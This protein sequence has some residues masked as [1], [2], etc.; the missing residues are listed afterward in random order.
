MNRYKTKESS[1][2]KQEVIP[3]INNNKQNMP[4]LSENSI[5]PKKLLMKIKNKS[6]ST[7]NLSLKAIKDLSLYVTNIPSLKEI[8]KT[9]DD[10]YQKNQL[11]NNKTPSPFIYPINF[12]TVKIEFP[13][14][15]ILNGYKSYIL[16]LKYEEPKF[17]QIV[18]KK[19]NLFKTIKKLK[20][21]SLNLSDS[22][23]TERGFDPNENKE[24]KIIVKNIIKLYQHNRIKY[25]SD[26]S[27]FS[28][29]TLGLKK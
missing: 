10:Y 28:L 3:L 6:K 7:E 27:S 20:L 24:K 15:T 16:F 1:N 17:K 14:E 26:N 11:K 23:S 4:V 22:Q 5:T 13:N 2:S 18:V 25:K 9:I 12:T 19:E 8:K 29:N 21:K